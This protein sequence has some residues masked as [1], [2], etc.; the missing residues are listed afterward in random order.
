M[1]VSSVLLAVSFI[2]LLAGAF[3]FTN[4]VE[5]A[6]LRLNLGHGATGSIL[7]AVATALPESVIPIVAIIAGGEEGS[8]AV[9][10]ILGAPFL[11]GTLAMLL[12][13]AAAY[14][15]R[16]RRSQDVELTADRS[17]TKRDLR[18]FLIILS[19]VLL[20]GVFGFR[21]LNIAAAVVF[22]VV[23]GVY[24][25]RTLSSQRETGEGEE[26]LSSLFFDPTKRDPPRNVQIILQVLAS[27]GLIIYGAHLFVAEVEHLAYGLGVSA[28]VLALV[29]APLASEL[30][31]K[32]NSFLW[33][34]S[35]KDTLALGNITGAM[36]FQS[37]IPVA[38]GLAFTDWDLPLAGVV[39]AICAVAG[40]ALCLTAFE[41]GR[42]FP[43]P[44]LVSWAVLYVGA[45]V[46]IISSA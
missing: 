42:R 38:A 29:L 36:V 7:A 43:L 1:V 33:V 27:L 14:G 21:G 23:Y 35:G 31:E 3:V 40:G 25:W 34:R 28:L 8:I 22:V 32:A 46:Y 11:L 37:M 19:I 17:S 4:A 15:F 45:T 24:V 16:Q 12:V 26:D 13:G 44:F 2:M 39:I 18:V 41:R 10:A 20:L 5:W 9:G 6:G 30:P